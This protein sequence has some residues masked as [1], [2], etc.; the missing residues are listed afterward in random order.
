MENVNATKDY[1]IVV[2][3]GKYPISE[4][5]Q[6][7]VAL[8]VNCNAGSYLDP[9]T[10]LCTPCAAASW[11]EGGL[12]E[13]C[14]PCPKGKTVEEG[15]GTSEA[16]CTW[17]PCDPGM[18]LDKELGCVECLEGSWSAGGLVE[19][20]TIC[21]PG[22][23]VAAGKGKEEPDCTWL[24]CN[25]AHFIEPVAGCS[26]CPKETWSPGGLV[27]GCVACR[28]GKTTSEGMGASDL[29]CTWIPC[30]PAWYL[31]QEK[32]CVQCPEGAYSN[33]GLVDMC[34]PCPVGK[35]VETGKGT[36]ESSCQ[37]LPCDAGRYL[38][39]V[40]GCM[41]C[42]EATY[43]VGAFSATCTPCAEGK[44]VAAGLGFSEES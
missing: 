9:V 1:T 19:A 16:T 7:V 33:G 13:V 10:K 12:L 34:L 35:I 20:C 29:D 41:E 32:G 40:S 24:P 18:Y 15:K 21:P 31:D 28:A 5:Y 8:T 3:S 23:T 6:L 27:E 44:T 43:S 22:K 17:L 30:Q 26:P 25:P 4:P 14:E 38:D 36:S 37:W 39:E 2:T 11:S 42:S